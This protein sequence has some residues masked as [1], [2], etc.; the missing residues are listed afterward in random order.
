M[1]RQL[2]PR[3]WLF[4]GLALAVGCQDAA[5]SGGRA[6]SPQDLLDKFE[7]ALHA[8]DGEAIAA[9]V[10]S[11]DDQFIRE[12][13]RYAAEIEAAQAELEQAL[14]KAFGPPPQ[15]RTERFGSQLADMT[16]AGFKKKDA[17]R[18][19]LE[20][21]I[22]S[23]EKQADGTLL[24]TVDESFDTPDGKKNQSETITVV[25]T[26]SGWKVVRPKD[27]TPVADR[28][29]HE[30]RLVELLRLRTK[31]VAAGLFKDRAEAEDLTA[32][33]LARALID[34]V[35][36]SEFLQELPQVREEA[37]RLR[38]ISDQADLEQAHFDLSFRVGPDK[39]GI[40]QIT[41]ASPDLSPPRKVPTA[42]LAKTLRELLRLDPGLPPHP[43]RIS[44]AKGIP[45]ED[46]LK[47]F[48]TLVDLR[49]D[50]PNGVALAI[51]APDE[52]KPISDKLQGRLKLLAA[53]GAA[54]S[55][56]PLAKSLDN[57]LKP[58]NDLK[59][60]ENFL[61]APSETPAGALDAPFVNAPSLNA[62]SLNAPSLNAPSLSAP[63]DG[64]PGEIPVSIG[65]PNGPK[66]SIPEAPP[67]ANLSG[68]GGGFSGNRPRGSSAGTRSP[69]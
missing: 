48:H 30:K 69:P 3:G 36:G 18:P 1:I 64:A 50:L 43:V 38:L 2:L 16:L 35:G 62:P 13:F 33:E 65:D 45:A 60:S 68:P 31:E 47:L 8:G 20:M 19:K 12:Q 41:Q 39:P 55:A 15:G 17:G 22:L 42:D 11:P 23:E 9:L 63:S 21:T 10:N 49:T 40:V 34:G 44:V 52:L 7:T 58:L 6:S 54:P 61:F 57:L 4:L 14:E 28:F 46:L 29:A 66:L 56:D 32:I 67:G 25:E 27:L 59:R 37:R 51:E 53:S 5:P 26:K 24:L